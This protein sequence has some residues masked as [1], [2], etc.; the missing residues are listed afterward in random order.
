MQL[1][2][3]GAAVEGEAWTGDVGAAVGGAMTEV[4]VLD[5]SAVG[6]EDMSG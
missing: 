4:P 3:V 6:P 5:G 1:F 2:L